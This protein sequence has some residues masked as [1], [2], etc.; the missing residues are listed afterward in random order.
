[1]MILLWWRCVCSNSRVLPKQSHRPCP[2]EALIC[3]YFPL[4]NPSVARDAQPGT[5]P[6]P[7]RNLTTTFPAN[8][9]REGGCGPLLQSHLLLSPL[10]PHPA[11]SLLPCLGHRW[12]LHA[13]P[14][15]V[16]LAPHLASS[17][18]SSSSFGWGASILLFRPFSTSVFV[19]PTA[20]CPLCVPRPLS[21]VPRLDLLGGRWHQYSVLAPLCHLHPFLPGGSPPRDGTSLLATPS[22]N[23]PTCQRTSHTDINAV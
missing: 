12:N 17:P 16:V 23:C 6:T 20:G 10:S 1:M 4:L 18:W 2:S 8:W 15:S 9:T 14:V 19:L 11:P 7:A 3:L 22:F 5:F 21:L 13:L